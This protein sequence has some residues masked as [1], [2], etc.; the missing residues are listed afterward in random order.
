MAET[1]AQLRELA[2]AAEK[3]LNWS[4]AERLYLLA[5]ARY[6]SLIGGLAQLDHKRLL[7]RAQSCA[8][9][10]RSEGK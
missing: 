8:D 7:D 5:A 10:A 9:T 6:P 3:Q 1:T 2:R 4:E